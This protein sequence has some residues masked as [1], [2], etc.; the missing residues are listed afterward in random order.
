MQ[1]ASG[2][3]HVL[4]CH[5]AGEEHCQFVRRHFSYGAEGKLFKDKIE[6]AAILGLYS[7]GGC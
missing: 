1:G 7:G 3:A 5:V 4:A 2:I 6:A